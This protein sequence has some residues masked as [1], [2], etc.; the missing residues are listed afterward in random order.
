MSKTA[1]VGCLINGVAIYCYYYCFYY[2]LWWGSFGPVIY[3]C[4]DFAFCCSDNRVCVSVCVT[5]SG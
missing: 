4:V 5:G 3:V 2:L 1:R